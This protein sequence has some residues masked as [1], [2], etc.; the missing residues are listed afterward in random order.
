L[1]ERPL[2]S[3][4]EVVDYVG[5]KYH[6][7][8]IEFGTKEQPYLGKGIDLVGK[9]GIKESAA[10]LSKCS[11]LLCN[12]SF[13]LHVAGALN[14]PIV[15]IFGPSAPD[16]RLPFNNISRGVWP[17]EGCRG[18]IQ[19]KAEPQLCGTDCVK[20]FIECMHAVRPEEVIEIIE[21]LIYNRT[22]EH[23]HKV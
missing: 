21:K 11:F 19:K 4:S 1:V 7:K 9:Y 12:D 5:N 6:A 8:I 10:V 23:H 20:S 18:C 13:F 15:G 22:E 3:F 16:K 17:R 2:E 14:V